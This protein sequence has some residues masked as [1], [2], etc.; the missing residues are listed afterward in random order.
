MNLELLKKL[1]QEATP[2]P[3][4]Q[5]DYGI[6]HNGQEGVA[7]GYAGSKRMLANAAYIVAACNEILPLVQRLEELQAEFR[8]IHD[9]LEDAR[10]MCSLKDREIAD[11]KAQL[12]MK[13]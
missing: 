6:I 13:R 3:W 5:G 7:M 8:S 12:R 4:T 2:G 1:A 9:R 10:F 11:L